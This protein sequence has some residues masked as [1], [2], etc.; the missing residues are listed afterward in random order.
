MNGKFASGAPIRPSRLRCWAPLKFFAAS[1]DAGFK[2][3]SNR[4][5]EAAFRLQKATAKLLNDAF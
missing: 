1:Q 4:F 2:V 5:V 3:Y